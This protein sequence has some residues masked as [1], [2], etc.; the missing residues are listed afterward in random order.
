[1]RRSEADLVSQIKQL[2]KKADCA[3]NLGNRA[4]AIQYIEEIM[5]LRDQFS[6]RL[7]ERDANVSLPVVSTCEKEVYSY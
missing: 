2:A 6:R 7:V 4:L 1:M 3:K 5:L